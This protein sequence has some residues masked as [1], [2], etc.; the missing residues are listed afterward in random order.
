MPTAVPGWVIDSVGPE[1]TIQLK[2]GPTFRIPKR[3]DL[4]WG[5]TVRVCY[6]YERMRPGQVISL[7]QLRSEMD[8]AEMPW[9]DSDLPWADPEEE[10][11]LP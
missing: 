11:L 7:E 3:P 10:E 6:D 4:G 1:L 5:D 9:L 8:A 2:T